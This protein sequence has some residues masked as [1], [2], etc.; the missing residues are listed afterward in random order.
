LFPCASKS[1]S[2]VGMSESRPS[3]LSKRVSD[4]KF[5]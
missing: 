4:N 5:G 2:S 1:T 3:P